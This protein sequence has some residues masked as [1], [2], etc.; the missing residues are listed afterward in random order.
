MCIHAQS[1]LFAAPRTIAHQALLPTEFSRQEHWSG[2]PLPT[3]GDPLDPGIK[4]MSLASPA[5]AGR[6]FTTSTIWPRRKEQW[7][8]KRL[9][10]TCPGVSKSLRQRRG[11]AVAW[12]ECS[13]ACR[14]PS[15][16]GDIIFITSAIVWSQVKQQGGNTIRD[17]IAN[18]CFDHRE[19]KR[20]PEKHLLPLYWLCQ[21]LWLCAS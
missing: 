1:H 2:M 3:P 16:G 13:S 4:P 12:T 20:V 11:S 7:P 6:F 14:G 10:Q 21:S 18:T 19:N 8:H 15:E 17:Q 5:L 9:T